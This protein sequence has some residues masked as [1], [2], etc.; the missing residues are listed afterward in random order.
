M[1]D[2]RH[3]LYSDPY[4]ANFE[5]LLV[6]ISNSLTRE[7]LQTLKVLCRDVVLRDKLQTIN[8][9]FELFHALKRLNK[10][11]VRDRDFLASKL[12]AMNRTDLKKQLL[13]I[14]G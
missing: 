8:H 5:A 13:E 11:S 2:R 14:A 6:R 3:Q 10:L 12:I 1:S 4:E 9:G 7:E